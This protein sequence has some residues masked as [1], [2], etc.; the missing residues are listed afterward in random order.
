MALLGSPRNS[1][2]GKV[3]RLLGAEVDPSERDEQGHKCL[4]DPAQHDFANWW[5]CWLR[6]ARMSGPGTAHAKSVR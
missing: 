2:I 6:E 5:T 4:H 1:L 3:R